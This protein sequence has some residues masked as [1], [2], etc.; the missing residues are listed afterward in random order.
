MMTIGRPEQDLDR[1][2]SRHPESK[3]IGRGHQEE[4]KWK[5][6]PRIDCKINWVRQRVTTTGA[7]PPTT[8]AMMTTRP[9]VEDVAQSSA[10][11]TAF[12]LCGI[13]SGT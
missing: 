10:I 9:A 13:A 5:I 1:C 2:Q 4:P 7:M 12:F 6:Q 11:G 3:E 8:N